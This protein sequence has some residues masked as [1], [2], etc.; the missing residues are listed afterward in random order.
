[1]AIRVAGTNK[2]EGFLLL[3]ALALFLKIVAKSPFHLP[4]LKS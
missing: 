3:F 2:K 4:S 1:M